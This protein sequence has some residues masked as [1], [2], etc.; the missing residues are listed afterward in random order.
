MTSLLA[1]ST[2]KRVW[3]PK[4]YVSIFLLNID[5]SL[6]VSM[7]TPYSEHMSIKSIIRTHELASRKTL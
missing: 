6:D 2:H 1:L 5:I 4:L 7:W 3:E